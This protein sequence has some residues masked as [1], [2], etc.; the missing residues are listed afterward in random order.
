M[1]SFLVFF[2]FFDLA[3]R[4]SGCYIKF[5][6]NRN[7]KIEPSLSVFWLRF[8]SV[9]IFFILAPFYPGKRDEG[10]WLVIGEHK[11]NSLLAI[12]HVSLQQK[13]K[14]AL[15]LVPQKVILEIFWSYW[16]YQ[17]I[18]WWD[19][20]C[21][22]YDVRRLRRMW[23]RVRDQFECCWRWR[24]IWWLI[25]SRIWRRRKDGRMKSRN[26]RWIFF[27]VRFRFS[28]SRKTGKR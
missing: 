19:K 23:S 9:N 8:D 24:L 7:G 11:T 27:R 22:V 6:K 26:L 12:K 17:I 15:E 4:N 16:H 1:K 13:K 10:W 5:I 14:I 20:I 2:M 3:A 25:R 28:F 21:S 18:G